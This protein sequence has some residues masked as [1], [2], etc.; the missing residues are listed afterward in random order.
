MFKDRAS[1]QDIEKLLGLISLLSGVHCPDSRP[2]PPH[3]NTNWAVA[4]NGAPPSEAHEPRKGEAT[5]FVFS[6]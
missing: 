2:P 1:R 5:G 4:H 3:I 6:R